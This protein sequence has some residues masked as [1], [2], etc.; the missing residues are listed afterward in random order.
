MNKCA[1]GA[2]WFGIRVAP[3]SDYSGTVVGTKRFN[4]TKIHILFYGSMLQLLN[5]SVQ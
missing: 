4:F 3:N 1:Q 2:S 5:T